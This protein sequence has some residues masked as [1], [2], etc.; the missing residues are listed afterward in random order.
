MGH[1]LTQPEEI[2]YILMAEKSGIEAEA[3]MLDGMALNSD[4][5]NQAGEGLGRSVRDACINNS[6]NRG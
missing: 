3:L 5:R 2:D 4:A 6:E 1:Y